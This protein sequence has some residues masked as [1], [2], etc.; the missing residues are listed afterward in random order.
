MGICWSA[1]RAKRERVPVPAVLPGPIASISS[2][3]SSLIKVL[4]RAEPL[5][6][7]VRRLDGRSI[8]GLAFPSSGDRTPFV[9]TAKEIVGSEPDEYEAR[10]NCHVDGSTVDKYA[11]LELLKTHIFARS[12]LGIAVF[13]SRRQVKLPP[14]LPA[15]SPSI[16]DRVH[17]LGFAS[18]QRSCTYGHVT[19]D[20]VESSTL[21]LETSIEADLYGCV[22]VRTDGYILGIVCECTDTSRVRFL[23]SH[24]V[25]DLAEKMTSYA[26][27]DFHREL[28]ARITQLGCRGAMMDDD[29]EVQEGADYLKILDICETVRH[30]PDGDSDAS[31]RRLLA[32]LQQLDVDVDNAAARRDNRD[33]LWSLQCCRSLQSSLLPSPALSPS[34][35]LSRVDR[36]QVEAMLQ[37]L[38]LIVALA[39]VTRTSDPL[40]HLYLEL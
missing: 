29:G 21:E 8:S 18:G 28:Q 37:Q 4:L 36:T 31:K 12:S 3:G 32:Q 39:I 2:S 25:H 6:V 16:G 38:S 5:I 22:V 20:S 34:R 17:V 11:E 23:G 24:A 30:L 14:S 26:G 15:C 19:A 10:Y 7:E 35:R 9:V 1:S 33:T 27:N 13:Q 40:R